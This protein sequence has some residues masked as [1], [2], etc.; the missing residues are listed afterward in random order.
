LKNTGEHATYSD[1]VMR[2]F[3]Q[4]TFGQVLTMDVQKSRYASSA[5]AAAGR[6]P[7]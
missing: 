2:I 6:L 3:Y 4:K 7:L 1:E 5:D